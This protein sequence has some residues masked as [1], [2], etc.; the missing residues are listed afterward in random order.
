MS[1]RVVCFHDVIGHARCL[2]VS[3]LEKVRSNRR[4]FQ[5]SLQVH[6][7]RAE[8]EKAGWQFYEWA[9][10]KLQQ[11]PEPVEAWGKAKKTKG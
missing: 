2:P 1:V 11:R 9:P 10:I 6:A 7:S 4:V 8:A 3:Y 5:H